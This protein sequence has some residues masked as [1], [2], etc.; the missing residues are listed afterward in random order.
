MG[1]YTPLMNEEKLE[2][3]LGKHLGDELKWLLRA[4]TEWH[5]Q[6]EIN[7]GIDG[8]NVQVYAMDS[9]FLRARVLFEFFT[10]K[11]RDNYY[12]CDAYINREIPSPLYKD[13]KSLLHSYVMHAQDRSKPQRLKSYDKS[14]DK[15]LN[16][17]PVDFAKEIV[18]LW[19]EFIDSLGGHSNDRIR[20]MKPL[21]QTILDEAISDAE[22]VI[23]VEM[24]KNGLKIDRNEL[25]KNLNVHP[26]RW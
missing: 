25:V 20:D 16:K 7:L 8:Y 4:A 14:G 18:R 6:N 13:W 5:V 11:T 17:M 1:R 26:I 10:G 3:Y 2:N 23:R 19:K 12:G 9:S 21:A 15:D 24:V 22:R